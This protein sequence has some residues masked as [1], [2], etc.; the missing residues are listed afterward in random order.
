VMTMTCLRCATSLQD[1][2]VF[3]ARCFSEL[4]ARPGA[5]RCVLR[6]GARLDAAVPDYEELD[7][8]APSGG[9]GSGSGSAR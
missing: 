1:L 9:G 6:R 8:L 4:L 2:V 5:P 7:D 3:R